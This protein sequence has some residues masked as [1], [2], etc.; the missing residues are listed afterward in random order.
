M[1]FFYWLAL[2]VVI[3]AIGYAT[4]WWVL[5]TEKLQEIARRQRVEQNLS[6]LHRQFRAILNHIPIAV[7]S[8]G[9]NGRYRIVNRA[10]CQMFG[11][12][13]ENVRGHSDA[14]LFPGAAG[15]RFE[16]QDR[17]M[18]AKG[19][20]LRQELVQNS[21]SG[22]RALVMVKVPVA[23]RAGA[24]ESICSIYADVTVQ[25]Q[26]ERE[27]E[28]QKALFNT[29]FDALPHPAFSK[30]ASGAFV[31]CNRAYE[32]AFGLSNAQL[33]GKSVIDVEIIPEH[34][35]LLCAREEEMLI[36]DGVATSREVSL[37]FAD[38]TQHTCLYWASGYKLRGGGSGGLT[39]AYFDVTPQREAE[40][41][42]VQA[43]QSTPWQDILNA[44]PVAAAIARQDGFITTAN[45]ALAK[46]LGRSLETVLN[47]NLS[48]LFIDAA[49]YQKVSRSLDDAHGVLR[50]C[51]TT[52]RR[53]YGGDLKALLTAR[54]ITLGHEVFTVLW[55]TDVSGM[56]H[57]QDAAMNAGLLSELSSILLEESLPVEVPI[58]APLPAVPPSVPEVQAETTDEGKE[59]FKA[60][61]EAVR[62]E[63]Q[64]L[65]Q[66]LEDGD[67]M[68]D[69]YFASV[70]NQFT[71]ALGQLAS[72]RL[73]SLITG[74]DFEAAL[75]LLST[76]KG[77]EE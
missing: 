28:R 68:A 25:K 10:W 6:A 37:V 3:F 15:L 40:Q 12:I 14:E 71:Q 41:A 35:R 70:E 19:K 66:M 59:V 77:H 42:I 7:S 31:Y 26:F 24:T 1:V 38:G 73:K 54:S 20:A 16:A 5:R 72:D 39:G 21:P 13:E 11:V 9:M 32:A 27:L 36:R 49:E 65:A 76:L 69:E 48:T 45:P 51:E 56:H 74:F 18:L 63:I 17:E 58:A 55:L 62:H 29:L 34:E 50:E 60:R 67:S 4:A 43:D 64:K 47:E 75:A 23:D 52:L 8:K 33:T 30:D 22:A 2:I 46:L 53:T 61:P 57:A 44:C